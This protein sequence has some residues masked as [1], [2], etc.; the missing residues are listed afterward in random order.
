MGKAAARFIRAERSLEKAC[1][2]LEAGLDCA[3]RGFQRDRASSP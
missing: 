1:Q 2:I 3:T